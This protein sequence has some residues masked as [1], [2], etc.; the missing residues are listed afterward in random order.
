M[1]VPE[2]LLG[3]LLRQTG[4]DPIKIGGAGQNGRRDEKASWI[5]SSS[6]WMWGA[7]QG[8]VERDQAKLAQKKG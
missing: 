7:G 2:R 4:T 5:H 3:S 8:R 1:I 6:V